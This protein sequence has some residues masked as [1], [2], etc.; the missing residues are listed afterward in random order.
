MFEIDRVRD[1][2]RK[3]GYIIHKGTETLVRDRERFE[4]ESVL[5]RESQLYFIVEI[6]HLR[7]Q[8]HI[9]KLIDFVTQKVVIQ[10]RR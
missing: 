5:D 3:I 8:M 2:E 6:A 10:Q 7:N 9:G 1:R 4:I